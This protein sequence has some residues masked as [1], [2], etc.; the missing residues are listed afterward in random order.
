MPV[1]EI[2]ELTSQ[3]DGLKLSLMTVCPE[4][5]PRA[6]VQLAHG[7]SEH[8][9]RYAPFME[10]L[11]ERGCA[12]VIN[13]HRGHGASVKS[14]DDLGYFYENG[15]EAL[16]NDLHQVTLWAKERWPGLPLFLF[17]HSM[18]S[19]AVR[20]YC[21]RYDGDIDALVVCGSPGE[22]GAAGFG[23]ALIK[24]L[25]LFKGDHYR[26]EMIRKMTTGSFDKRT[27]KIAPEGSWLSANPNNALSFANDPLCG[28]NFT[29]NGNRALLKLM[30]RA[31]GLSKKRGK[32]ELPVHFYSGADDSCA[33]NRAGFE[34]A[35]ERMR[36]AG[37]VDVS[38]YMFPGL[39]HEI[40]NE[41]NKEEVWGRIWTEALEPYIR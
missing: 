35:M 23:L 10:Y 3:Q 9:G 31:Y 4:G 13:D 14:P 15:D 27:K 33:P 12:C 6:I 38:G 24:L 34:H 20:A 7:M 25:T 5:A 18:G 1:K 11:A 30:Q 19:L 39:R 32:P 2:L 36:E 41:R 8:K 26:S 37:Y 21:E 29:L 17:G 40:L 28:F 16:V 22:N